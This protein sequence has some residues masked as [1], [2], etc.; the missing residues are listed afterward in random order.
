M[1]F[2]HVTYT[3]V[4]FVRSLSSLY[5][6]WFFLFMDSIFWGEAGKGV[7]FLL[8]SSGSEVRVTEKYA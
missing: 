6:L 7:A 3:A 1:K 5:F 2:G 4:R 8:C